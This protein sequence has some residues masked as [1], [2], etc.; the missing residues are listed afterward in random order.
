MEM[1]YLGNYESPEQQG[2]QRI[3]LH[4]ATLLDECSNITI[5]EDF[6]CNNMLNKA[7]FYKDRL[8]KFESNIDSETQI[9]DAKVNDLNAMISKLQAL[10]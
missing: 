9:R 5:W 6:L 10:K 3:L 7:N 4:V 1:I 8:E 2:H